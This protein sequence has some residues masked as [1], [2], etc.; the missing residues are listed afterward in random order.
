MIRAEA[1]HLMRTMS[2]AC[3][4]SNTLV[5]QTPTFSPFNKSAVVLSRFT[6][7]EF[8]LDTKTTI[9]VEFATKSIEVDDRIMRAHM[10]DTAGQERYRA[11]SSVYYRGA[12]GALIVYDITKYSSFENVATWLQELRANTSSGSTASTEE[13]IVIMLVGNKS[14]MK[15]LRAVGTEEGRKFAEKNN[16]S[17]IETSALDASNVDSA[18]TSVLHDIFRLVS[19]HAPEAPPNPSE[20][21]VWNR[22]TTR[23]EPNKENRSRWG[24]CC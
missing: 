3:W 11:M 10:W 20:Y 13:G 9:G 22:S 1:H 8:K 17:F 12:I 2:S 21:F 16:L 23:I 7:D 24:S 14:D 4:I 18:F 15:H 6:R 5:N 19:R